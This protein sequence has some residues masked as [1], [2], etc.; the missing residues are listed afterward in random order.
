MGYPNLDSVEVLDLSRAVREWEAPEPDPDAPAYK[1]NLY[2]GNDYDGGWEAAHP[3]VQELA[4]HDA[5]GP[6]AA[7]AYL[8]EGS[9][10]NV[11]ALIRWMMGGAFKGHFAGEAE[12]CRDQFADAI[13]D[14]FATWDKG[15][16]IGLPEVDIA[17]LIDWDEV[18][19]KAVGDEPDQVFYAISADNGVY[20]F[21][22]SINFWEYEDEED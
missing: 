15:P 13:E 14:H 22:M 21:D 4:R 20:V 1:V 3:L 7:L 11:P 16:D 10:A 9:E 19:W 12:F 6:A 2:V 18:A 5:H 8:A 17:D